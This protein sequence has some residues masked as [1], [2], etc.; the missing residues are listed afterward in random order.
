MKLRWVVITS[1]LTLHNSP[2]LNS[3]NYLPT[4]ESS[5]PL[6]LSHSDR[7]A[8]EAWVQ[9]RLLC[10][11]A[12]PEEVPRRAWPVHVQSFH[13]AVQESVTSPPIGKRQWG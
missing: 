4:T 5:H 8:K 3:C 11:Q 1:F 12:D 7:L 13:Q 6:G 2:K 10:G 9:A